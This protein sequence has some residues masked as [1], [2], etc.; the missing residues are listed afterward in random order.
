MHRKAKA[1]FMRQTTKV[2]TTGLLAAASLAAGAAD[3]SPLMAERWHTR[4]LVVV[5]PSARHPLLTGLQTQLGRPEMR[6]AFEERE[7]VLFTVIADEG[8][9]DGKALSA[10][11][12]R[13]LKSALKLTAI[14]PAT[15][16]LIGKDGGVKLTE[17]SDHVSLQ[18]LFALIDSMPMRQ[19]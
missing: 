12:T 3:D 16:F 5:A 9:R 1:I 7:M 18:T 2:L 6:R 15:V 19:R 10:G 4:P 17:R 11:Q 13:S 14:S 8:H